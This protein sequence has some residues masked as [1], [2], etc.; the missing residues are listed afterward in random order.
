MSLVAMAARCTLEEILYFSASAKV[1]VKPTIPPGQL[2]F[3]PS[4]NTT[5]ILL[6]TP[7]SQVRTLL[8]SVTRG[9]SVDNTFATSDNFILHRNH[10]IQIVGKMAVLKRGVVDL[11]RGEVKTISLKTERGLRHCKL[12]LPQITIL[13]FISVFFSPK[14]PFFNSQKQTP[15]LNF[16]FLFIIK[17]DRN[18]Y[19]FHK[20]YSTGA[21]SC[22]SFTCNTT[23]LRVKLQHNRV[24]SF[25]WITSEFFMTGSHLNL[26]KTVTIHI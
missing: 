7:P 13:T 8:S 22:Y 12:Y 3:F 1:C 6:I 15:F 18:N 9:G 25:I 5:V 17:F 2:I 20:C 23:D 21:A 11:H 19:N 24:A 10:I 14:I 26:G 16:H 4:A